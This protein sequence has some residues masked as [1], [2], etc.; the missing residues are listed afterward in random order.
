MKT[1]QIQA[2]KHDAAALLKGHVGGSATRSMVLR[3]LAEGRVKLAYQPVVDARD[4][5]RVAFHEALVRVRT[6]N[7]GLL[8]PAQFL[9]ALA[10][11]SLAATL[12]REV[13]RQALAALRRQPD[14]RLAINAGQATCESDGWLGDLAA[15]T[16]QGPDLG[17]RMIVELAEDGKQEDPA[18]TQF[19]AEL[20]RLGVSVALDD[21]GAG[22]TGF[23]QFR[24]QRFDIVKID[25][26]YGD[27]LAR[28]RDAQALVRALVD[29]ARHFEMVS[30]IEF[31]ANP[32]DAACA[33]R[34]GV[35]AMQGK[36]YGPPLDALPG[37]G[38]TTRRAAG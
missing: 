38:P 32:E 35:D 8:A 14:L 4:T 18:R 13:L 19:V 20:H 6:A 23:A 29:L 9:P 30:V 11:T 26:S 2:R 5:R 22:R 12:D 3:A 36:L 15:A 24:Q 16:R 28:D 21:F 10:G 37:E 1:K 34:L 25:G 33:R 7:G 31:I 27:G 17:Y